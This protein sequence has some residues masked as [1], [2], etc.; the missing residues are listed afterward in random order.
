M[1]IEN[2]IDKIKERGYR[3]TQQREAILRILSKAKRPITAKTL[4]KKLRRKVN[5][6]TIYRNLEFLVENNLVK[7][8]Y[9]EDNFVRYELANKPHHH[10]LICK[11][12]RKINPIDSDALEDVLLITQKEIEK[13]YKFKIQKH[14]LEF[15]GECRACSETT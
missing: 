3:I 13:T 8:Y 2:L 9:F 4:Q 10:H 11:T 6:A 15:Y 7:E 12:C 14:V 1:Q 5:K